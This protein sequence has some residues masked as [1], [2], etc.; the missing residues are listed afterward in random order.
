MYLNTAQ[1]TADVTLTP[2]QFSKRGLNN[3]VNRLFYEV[4]VFNLKIEPKLIFM[5]FVDQWN[6]LSRSCQSHRSLD[7]KN[8][9]NL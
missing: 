9:L 6:K 7:K 4:I 8:Y 1:L 2:E 5:F 3:Y